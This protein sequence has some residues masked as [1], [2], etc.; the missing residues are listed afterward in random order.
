VL[1]FVLIYDVVSGR[2][3]RTLVAP[4]NAICVRLL[5]ARWVVSVTPQLSEHLRGRV[6]IVTSQRFVSVAQTF[7]PASAWHM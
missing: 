7:R 3:S 2:C 5:Q 4:R 1:S 6:Y